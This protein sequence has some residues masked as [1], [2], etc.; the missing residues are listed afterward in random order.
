V[1]LPRA[2]R[3]RTRTPATKHQCLSSFFLLPTHTKLGRPRTPVPV[4]DSRPPLVR[5]LAILTPLWTN[6]TRVCLSPSLS[7]PIPHAPRS[8]DLSRRAMSATSC[9]NS[10]VLHNASYPRRSP[11]HRSSLPPPQTPC[12]TSRPSQASSFRAS[13]PTTP[14]AFPPRHPTFSPTLRPPALSKTP[15]IPA[16][17]PPVAAPRCPRA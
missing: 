6:S 1:P 16:I 13:L 9:S 11:P 10:P 15:Q 3:A 2:W 12:S 5:R 4:T 7:A 14:P 17:V 8:R